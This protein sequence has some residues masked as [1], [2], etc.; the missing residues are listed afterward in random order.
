[1][2]EARANQRGGSWITGDGSWAV[3]DTGR[4]IELR[5]RIADLL[6]PD[7]REQAAG[8]YLQ[9]VAIESW[10][11]EAALKEPVDQALLPVPELPEGTRQVA[12]TFGEL[13]RTNRAWAA[14]ALA[15][16]GRCQEAAEHFRRLPEYDR[17]AGSGRARDI[18][19]KTRPVAEAAVDCFELIGDRRQLEAWNQRL[20]QEPV[21]VNPRRLS[22]TQAG[23][24]GRIGRPR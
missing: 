17:L 7:R 14:V 9:N 3:R 19:W 5:S 6:G 22:L 18:V 11:R 4:A 1:L 2:E 23:P 10:F 20:E 24:S 13:M 21:E 16:L 15:K 8:L 12:P